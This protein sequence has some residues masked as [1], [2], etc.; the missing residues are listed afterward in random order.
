MKSAAECG[1]REVLR[2]RCLCC[3]LLLWRCAAARV[4]SR[5]GARLADLA[6]AFHKD[7]EGLGLAG[8]GAIRTAPPPGDRGPRMALRFKTALH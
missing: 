2:H 7:S 6:A 4:V 3:A 8:R 1:T 5:R